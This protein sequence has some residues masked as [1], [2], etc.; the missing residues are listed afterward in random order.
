ML[1]PN[2][3][4]I[5]SF[6]FSPLSFLFLHCHRNSSFSFKRY[7]ISLVSI[8]LT[9]SLCLPFRFSAPRIPASILFLPSHFPQAQPPL[10]YSQSHLQSDIFKGLIT[11][12]S[13]SL[14][15]HLTFT[16][17]LLRPWCSLLTSTHLQTSNAFFSPTFHLSFMLLFPSSFPSFFFYLFSSKP[18]PSTPDPTPTSCSLKWPQRHPL[19]WARELC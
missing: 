4:V 2:P 16:P 7:C 18:L 11:L 9:L 3:D 14:I 13:H 6:F 19:L 10:W 15:E 8:N 1:R 5:N 12:S 17:H